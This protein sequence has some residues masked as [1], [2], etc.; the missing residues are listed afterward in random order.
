MGAATIVDRTDYDAELKSERDIPEKREI[1]WH[2]GQVSFVD[3]VL[4]FRQKPVTIWFTGL[5]GSGKSTLAFALERRLMDTSKACYVLDG[6]NV[7]HGLNRDLG[8]SPKDRTE[9][10]RRISE[11]ARLMN[12]AGLVVI[13]AFISPFR[14]DREM[15]RRIISAEN[16]VEIFLNPGLETCEGRDPKGLYK[17]ARTGELP[18]FTGISSPYELPESPALILDTGRL[19]IEQ[20]TE[21]IQPYLIAPWQEFG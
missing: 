8:F 11:V 2:K 17:K 19:S 6:D 7:R 9:N 16:F 21:A 14:E 5:S 18:G 13:T 12:D 15:A 10:I 4:F 3:R 20:C 1:V